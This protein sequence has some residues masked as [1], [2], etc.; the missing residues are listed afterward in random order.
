MQESNCSLP[1]GG[2]GTVLFKVNMWKGEE[3]KM[4]KVV[5]LQSRGFS[6]QLGQWKDINSVILNLLFYQPVLV[7]E[8][9]WIWCQRVGM[10]SH[11]INQDM[12][13][14][15]G[16]LKRTQKET[17]L[18]RLCLLG[19]RKYNI[20]CGFRNN[21]LQINHVVLKCIKWCENNSAAKERI[22]I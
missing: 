10:P 7:S 4:C 22:Y 20:I 5:P 12:R 2:L 3:G 15:N 16:C 6:R 18:S 13:T 11:R 1:R 17:V 8:I 19:C 21:L 9:Y 14:E